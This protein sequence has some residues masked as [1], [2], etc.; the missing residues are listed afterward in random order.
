[1]PPPTLQLQALLSPHRIITPTR[2]NL[3]FFTNLDTMKNNT[4]T[5]HSSILFD[6][7]KKAFVKNVSIQIDRSKGVIAKVYERGDDD[8]A[9]TLNDGDIDLRGKIVLPGFVDSHTHI[10]LYE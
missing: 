5:I 4:F 3:T 2:G 1:L 10:F 7:R 6:A 9:L 8:D